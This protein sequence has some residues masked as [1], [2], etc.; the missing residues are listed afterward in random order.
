MQS[1]VFILF[2]VT[3][4][5]AVESNQTDW[6]DTIVNNQRTEVNNR[7][8]SHLK[9]YNI[10]NAFDLIEA[11]G[12]PYGEDT[13]SA[14]GSCVENK[15]SKP[16]EDLSPKSV[17]YIRLVFTPAY[18]TKPTVLVMVNVSDS[19]PDKTKAISMKLYDKNWMED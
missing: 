10:T 19:A 5:V 12:G 6:F 11:C 2:F 15:D 1:K 13:A 9:D 3:L 17:N 7:Y 16:M 4:C 18:F 14:P 8:Y